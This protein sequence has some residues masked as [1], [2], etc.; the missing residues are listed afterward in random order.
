VT[1]DGTPE[2]QAAELAAAR[3][4]RQEPAPEQYRIVWERVR[5]HFKHQKL[6]DE[7]TA[8]NRRT[9]RAERRRFRQL[10]ARAME[11]GILVR[12]TEASGK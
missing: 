11:L 6:V 12:V 3:K 10:C 9:N 7:I 5:G 1:Y 2:Q 8:C 4:R